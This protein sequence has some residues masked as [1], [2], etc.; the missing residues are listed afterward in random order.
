MVKTIGIKRFQEI[1]MDSLSNPLQ[2]AGKSIVLWNS[3]SGPDSIEYKIVEECCVN[4]NN[5][6]IDNQVWFKEL[7]FLRQATYAITSKAFCKR[8]DM[9]GYKN[10]GILLD[11]GYISAL[12]PSNEEITHWLN[13]VNSQEYQGETLSSDW[14]LITCAQAS[15]YSFT[16]EM[17]SKECVLY[18]FKPSVDEWAQWM[19]DKCDERDLKPIV[20]FIKETESSIDLFYWGLVLEALK[21]EL[22]EKEYEVL[23]QLSYEEFDSCLGLDSR[24]H[25]GC[26]DFPYDE[27]WKYI[28]NNP[29]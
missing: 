20:A 28:Q 24:I 21:R 10:M 18:E 26:K 3:Y 11:S 8:K 15:Y 2:Y 22:V 4:Y 14:T 5:G 7:L 13:F 16:E 27:L 6:H 9:Y 25:R 1:V 29:S 23:S 17:F 19:K 12:R